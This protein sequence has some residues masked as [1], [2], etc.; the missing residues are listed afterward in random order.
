[1]SDREYMTLGNTTD[2]RDPKFYQSWVDQ[3]NG[4][5]RRFCIRFNIVEKGSAVLSATGAIDD[6][7]DAIR[8]LMTDK[9]IRRLAIGLRKIPLAINDSRWGRFDLPD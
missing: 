6:R 2:L 7:K 5:R 8:L 9:A 4:G 3:G 1:M